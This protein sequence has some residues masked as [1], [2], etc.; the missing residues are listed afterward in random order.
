MSVEK[1]CFIP[2]HRGQGEFDLVL[3]CVGRERLR[4]SYTVWV[5]KHVLFLYS[6]V[7]ESL[8]YFCAVRAE[9]ACFITIQ[10]G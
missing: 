6:V 10:C 1:A 3:Q 9:N 4:Y 2:V 7:K 8:L 5:G